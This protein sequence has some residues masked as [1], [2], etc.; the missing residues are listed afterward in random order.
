MKQRIEGANT[1]ELDK[2]IYSLIPMNADAD[3]LDDNPIY[4]VITKLKPRCCTSHFE[5]FGFIGGAA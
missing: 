5:L 4:Q 1:P 3:E 2:H